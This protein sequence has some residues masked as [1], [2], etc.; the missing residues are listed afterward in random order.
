[1]GKTNTKLPFSFKSIVNT[2]EE[3]KR[4]NV[5]LVKALFFVNVCISAIYH[6]SN[7]RMENENTLYFFKNDIRSFPFLVMSK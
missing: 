1:M 6:F 7:R 2:Q 3:K 5:D 4:K